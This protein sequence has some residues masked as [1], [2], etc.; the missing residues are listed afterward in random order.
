MDAF[1]FRSVSS[2]SERDSS[3]DSMSDDEL[4][5]ALGRAVESASAVGT[6]ATPVTITVSEAVAGVENIRGVNSPLLTRQARMTVGHGGIW[7]EGT[8]F[9]TDTSSYDHPIQ[10]ERDKNVGIL[11]FDNVKKRFLAT[12]CGDDE[13]YKEDRELL[14]KI[15]TMTRV[16][17]VTSLSGILILWIPILGAAAAGVA[18][19]LIARFVITGTKETTC[20]LW[21]GADA[22]AQ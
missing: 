19:E 13:K 8:F 20:Q 5:A 18:A 2:Y 12:L 15:L 10:T 21:S 11:F 9:P 7:L 1:E 16:A 4:F 22:A 14:E 3:L 17:I 6:V